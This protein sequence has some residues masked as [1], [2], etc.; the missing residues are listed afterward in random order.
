[1]PEY[2][3]LIL[4]I[5]VVLVG[6][7]LTLVTTRLRGRGRTPTPAP[8]TH[9]AGGPAERRGRHGSADRSD[10]RRGRRSRRRAK[11]ESVAS[12]LVRLRQRLARS[13]SG[14][15]RGLLA[16][17]SRDVSTRTPGR[18]S[19]TPLITADVGVTPT[20]ELV[21]RLRTRLKV[22]GGDGAMQRTS[23]TTSCV[24]L[25]DPTLDRSLGRPATR[26]QARRGADGRRQRH[27]QDHHG[28]QARPDPGRRGQARR[29]RRRRHVPRRRGRAAHHLGRAGRCRTCAGPRAATPPASRSRRSGGASRR[30][31]TW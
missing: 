24:T 2:L 1:M 30:R 22:E 16:L 13:Q 6:G 27:R 5:A 28:R 19:R 29:A 3:L 31:P 11:P 17:L 10:H 7:A 26:R 9:A 23:S 4:G 25:V 8:P 18:T 14:L 20:Q 12:R 15:G 21:E